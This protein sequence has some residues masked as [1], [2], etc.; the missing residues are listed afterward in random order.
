MKATLIALGVIA[1]LAIVVFVSVRSIRN[2][3]IAKDKAVK[4]A[5]AGVET[6]LE[7]RTDLIPELLEGLEGYLISHE[8]LGEAVAAR[9]Q[10]LLEAAGPAAKGEADKALASELERLMAFTRQFP[11][12]Q[13]HTDFA[14]IRDELAAIAGRLPGKRADYN[15]AVRAYNTVIRKSPGSF[16]AKHMEL[17]P[18][19][20]FQPE[21]G[22]E[23]ALDAEHMALQPK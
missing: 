20:Y 19:E 22:S 17:Y 3:L 1:V 2:G 9:R 11:E 21:A 12:L 18:A 4:T 10:Q 6:D 16:F 7:Q 14:R 13:A 23:D 5:W 8:E 15:D